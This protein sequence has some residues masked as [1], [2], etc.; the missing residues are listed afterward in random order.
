MIFSRTPDRDFRCFYTCEIILSHIPV[1]A[2]GKHKKEQPHAGRTSI[3]D[4][5]VMLKC[6]HHTASQQIQDFLED[7]SMLF[8]FHI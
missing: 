1:P 8:F 4:I 3:L 7:F 6:C 5:I 2:S